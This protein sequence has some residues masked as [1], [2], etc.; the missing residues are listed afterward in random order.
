VWLIYL[1]VGDVDESLARVVAEGGTVL[2][3]IKGKDGAYVYAAIEDPAGAVFAIA[4]G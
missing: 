4:P 2:R 3:S 1:P